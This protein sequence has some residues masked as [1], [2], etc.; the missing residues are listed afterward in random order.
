MQLMEADIP[1]YW[2]CG[3]CPYSDR[4][5]R[6]DRVDAASYLAYLGSAYGSP[7]PQI[8]YPFPYDGGASSSSPPVSG[9]EF[10]YKLPQ[11]FGSI[12][13]SSPYS[14]EYIPS[15]PSYS[16]SATETAPKRDL[17]SDIFSAVAL[18]TRTGSSGQLSETALD[19]ILSSIYK[20]A[21]RPKLKTIVWAESPLEGAKL[22]S[23]LMDKKAKR[24]KLRSWFKE[25]CK[26]TETWFN[27]L[28]RAKNL[29]DYKNA[30]RDR[31]RTKIRDPLRTVLRT[32]GGP[33][34]EKALF[35]DNLMGP[36]DLD[37]IQSFKYAQEL[38]GNRYGDTTLDPLIALTK[39]AG[40][41][42]SFEDVA[43]VSRLPNVLGLDS[44]GRLHGNPALLFA[45]GFRIQ[46][47]NGKVRMP[48]AYDDRFVVSQ[49][50]FQGLLR[51]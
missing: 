40:W 39:F 28:T 8:N 38:S 17:K 51:P 15:A 3:V 27:D 16:S 33:K 37:W 36:H 46:A 18:G 7:K 20:A 43:V 5:D 23:K 24:I 30:L 12:I 25:Y 9:I 13:L 26:N 45:D 48:T 19:S 6:Y 29:A 4:Y 1:S 2:K 50:R 21:G 47:E 42:W 44:E 34:I 11:D 41:W 35:A 32:E 14:Y 22:A 10:K 49:Q 31:L